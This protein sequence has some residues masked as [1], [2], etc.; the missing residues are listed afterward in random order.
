MIEIVVDSRIRIPIASLTKDVVE[1]L[2]REFTHQNPQ[3]LKKRAMGYQAWD[4]PREY[5]TFAV[6][7][8]E[9]SFPR[10]GWSRVTDALR[11]CSLEFAVV[12]RR[13]LGVPIARLAGKREPKQIPDHLLTLRDY[14]EQAVAAAIEAETCFV[15]APTGS[16]K[17]TVGFAI[18][19]RLKKV[20]T[21]VIVWSGGLFNQWMKR[22]Q[23]EL[24]YKA[25][26]VGQ[27]RAGKVKLRPLTIAMQQS[28]AAVFEKGGE[29]AEEI[30]ESFGVVVCDELQ[31]FAARTLFATVD[32]F[33]AKYRIGISADERRKDSREFLIYDLFDKPA[34]D[35]PR[36]KLIDEGHV[37]DVEIRVVPTKFDSLIRDDFSSLVEA[38]TLDAGRNRIVDRIVE[39]EALK[40]GQQLLI[41]THRREHAREI[42]ARVA[43]MGLSSG[44]MLGTKDDEAI[45][46]ETLA[47]LLDGT[48]RVGVGTV[49]SIGQGID[50]PKLGVG[51]LTMPMHTNRQQ[52]GQVRGRFCRPE[53]DRARLYY[54]WDR[55]YYGLAALKAVV[56]MNTKVVVLDGGKWVEGKQ[57]LR[58]F[59]DRP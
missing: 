8:R 14:Q 5:K 32:P 22:A 29:V 12:D 37:L 21:I 13:I 30:L 44:T 4:E 24:G 42:D 19:S 51:I 1:I 45:F 15:R 38:M 6:T 25:S 2:K 16:G 50:L 49:Q 59:R 43:R 28:L 56:A 54:L 10:G 47:G 35:I 33:R 7:D 20:P 18:P 48:K 39:S 53:K 11:A 41:L 40:Q 57:F 9:V 3:W 34:A 17:T 52:F 31:R 36:Q 27:V 55:P 58:Q 23:T 26:E 46:E